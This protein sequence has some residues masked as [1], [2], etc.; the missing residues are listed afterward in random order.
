M[1]EFLVGIRILAQ[2]SEE[3]SHRRDPHK[4]PVALTLLVVL[5]DFF[6]DSLESAGQLAWVSFFQHLFMVL[7]P[8]YTLAAG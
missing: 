4:G 1:D 3:Q 5:Q 6:E 7:Q 8:R 2:E